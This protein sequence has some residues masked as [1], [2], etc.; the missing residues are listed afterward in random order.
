M[1][2][3]KFSENKILKLDKNKVTKI[4]LTIEPFCLEEIDINESEHRNGDNS[5]C[6]VYGVDDKINY[7]INNYEEISISNIQDMFLK[8][9]ID[10]YN[11]MIN[12]KEKQ[13]SEYK[14]EINLIN[15]YFLD[16]EEFAIYN[17]FF[18]DIIF[19]VKRNNKWY[20]LSTYD[21]NDKLDELKYD[22]VENKFKKY[23]KE[24]FEKIYKE[25][26]IIKKEDFI[27]SYQKLILSYK[28]NLHKLLNFNFLEFFL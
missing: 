13:I 19:A 23:S 28:K 7:D 2:F 6:F 26:L 20:E 22:Y 18:N 10:S 8:Y 27:S 5:R 14:E 4:V 21:I 9:I 15:S 24:Q 11:E 3:Y 25:H 12:K 16:F 17:F 1:K